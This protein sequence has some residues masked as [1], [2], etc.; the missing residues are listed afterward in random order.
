M[1]GSALVRDSQAIFSAA[2]TLRV[3]RHTVSN[4]PGLSRCMDAH[5]WTVACHPL[6]K[7][8]RGEKG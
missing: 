4:Q 5:L 2:S 6:A 8:S 3:L 1:K 7:T